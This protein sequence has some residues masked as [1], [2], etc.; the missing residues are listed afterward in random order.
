M[1][2]FTIEIT[3]TQKKVNHDKHTQILDK[4]VTN[5]NKNRQIP[6]TTQISKMNKH[7]Q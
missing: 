7:T 4:T 6:N 5:H 1:Q 2:Y 3:Y